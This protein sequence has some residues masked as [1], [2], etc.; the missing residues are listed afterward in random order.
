MSHEK[1]RMI[2]FFITN[3]CN[4][5]CTYCVNDTANVC[6]EQS[7]DI[8]F[9]KKGLEDFFINKPELFG[10]NNNHIRFYA[11]GEPTTKMDLV[12]E[13]TEYAKSIRK[14]K[15]FVE[16]Q[17]NGMFNKSSADWIAKN[18]NEVWA[19]IDGPSS[20]QN[21]YRP[22]KDGSE[23]SNI[24]ENNIKY[25][26]NQGIFVG[27][28]PTINSDTVTKQKELIDYFQGLGIDW[29]YAEP[30]FSSVKQTGES[31]TDKITAI[32]LK[33]FVKEFIE[34]HNYA[35]NKGI[36]YGNF[37]TM[38]FD[39]PCNYGCR[40][41]LPMPQLT[42]DGYVSSCDLA[43][44]GKTALNDFIFGKYDKESNIINYFP[45]KIAKIRTRH[46]SQIP[47][48]TA[49]EVKDNCGGGCA[50]LAYYATG[51]L[52]GTVPEFCESIK[53]LANHMERNTGKIE[54]Q[55]P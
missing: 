46:V 55:H 35:K 17:T 12:K 4:L 33:V 41:C 21:K 18:V 9:A 11:V 48:C 45:E 38:N 5:A 40:S 20:I 10:F 47:E 27:V 31:I 36:H 26:K 30:M 23:S 8:N 14:D 7:I 49:C 43:Y 3:K 50:G 16:L 42:P 13:I 22:A 32:D 6:K 25:L 51:K 44:S 28:R 1:K 34:A 19:S 2:T 52:Q 54:H 24:V 37:F 39:E 29:I 53:Y 15:L